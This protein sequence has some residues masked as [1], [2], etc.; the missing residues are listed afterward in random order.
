MDVTA[1]C[2]YV[3]INMSYVDIDKYMCHLRKNK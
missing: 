1:V 3:D 2:V